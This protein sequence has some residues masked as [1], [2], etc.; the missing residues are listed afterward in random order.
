MQSPLTLHWLGVVVVVVVVA[1]DVVVVVVV[2]GNVVVVVVVTGNVVVVVVVAGGVVVVDV[3]AN[4]ARHWNGL[5][6]L[7]GLV[8]QTRP[9]LQHGRPLGLQVTP[10]GVHVGAAVVVVVGACVVVG[11]WVVVDATQP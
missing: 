6:G 10:F 9:A 2:A 7:S 8:R 1:G 11:A 4:G 5:P 3:V